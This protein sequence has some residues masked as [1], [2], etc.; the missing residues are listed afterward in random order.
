[1]RLAVPLLEHALVD[2]EPLTFDIMLEQVSQ[3]AIG[4]K[5]LIAMQNNFTTIYDEKK[6]Q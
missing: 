2:T 6:M 5:L 1:M 3:L 4:D